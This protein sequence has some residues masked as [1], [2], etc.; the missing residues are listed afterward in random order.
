MRTLQYLHLVK[1]NERTCGGYV[2]KTNLQILMRNLRV[3]QAYSNINS[4]SPLYKTTQHQ[5]PHFAFL[6][7]Q[8]GQDSAGLLS[9]ISN[10]PLD[11]P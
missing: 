4:M 3:I 8:Q 11:A 9:T 10:Q 5:T 1:T 7:T 2:P 6:I